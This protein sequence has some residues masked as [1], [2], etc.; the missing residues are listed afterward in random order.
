MDNLHLLF[1]DEFKFCVRLLLELLDNVSDASDLF[2]QL[3]E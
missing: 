2:L 3:L 1:Q